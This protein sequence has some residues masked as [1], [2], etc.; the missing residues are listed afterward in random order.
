MKWRMIHNQGKLILGTA[1]PRLHP[2]LSLHSQTDSSQD[3]IVQILHQAVV[4]S[5]PAGV[6]TLGAW[7]CS[8]TVAASAKPSPPCLLAS[9]HTHILCWQSLGFSSL[10]FCPSSFPRSQG[11]F[12]PLSRTVG[13]GNPLCGWTHSLPRARS[14]LSNLL[15]LLDPSKGSRSQLYAFFS[16]QS[17][18]WKSF[19]QLWLYG[20]FSASFQLVLHV[21]CFTGRYIFDVF[22][23]GSELHIFLLN[24]V[25]PAS[26]KI[27]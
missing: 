14:A 8:E 3:P 7:K 6:C 27:F 13:L 10:S 21:N 18:T 26:E 5:D 19:L 4:W 23:G 16:V 24:N 9:Q 1:T 15:F 12:S 2:R 17:V 11:I 20:N 25:Y 22:V